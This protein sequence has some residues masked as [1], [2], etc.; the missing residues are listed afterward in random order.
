M[1]VSD[2]LDMFK[3]LFARKFPTA[4]PGRRVLRV[5]VHDDQVE[6]LFEIDPT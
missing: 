1:Q 3:E 2:D 4:E 6:T 5:I